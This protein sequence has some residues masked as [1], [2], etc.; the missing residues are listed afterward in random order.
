M[1][2]VLDASVSACWAL[3]DE[4]DTIAD[5][6]LDRSDVEE[7]VVPS[8]WWFEIRNI[9]IVAERRKRLTVATTD[10]FLR[11]IRRL[12]LSIDRAPEEKDVILLARRHGLT[13]YDSG[14][15]E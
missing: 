5:V 6:A 9:L 14:Y 2:F 4:E 13:V 10:A 11:S 15:L 12:K 1:G 3:D 7:I 8:L